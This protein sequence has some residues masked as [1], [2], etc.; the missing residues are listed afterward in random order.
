[1]K[2]LVTGGE[3]FLGSYVVDLLLQN[4]YEVC[5][6]SLSQKKRIVRRKVKYYSLDI[7][8]RYINN[9]FELEKPDYV[10]HNAAHVGIEKSIENPILDAETNI[11]GTL[12]ILEASRT[13]N[14]KKIIYPVTSAIYGIPQ[15]TPIDEIHPINIESPYGVSNYAAE[16]YIK[17]YNKLY[18][19]NYVALRYAN[20]YGTENGVIG[21]FCSL[22]SDG[23]SPCIN[24]N[25]ENE[26]DYV[27]IKDAAR[28]MLMALECDI[29]GVYNVCSSVGVSL[30]RL[31]ELINSLLNTNYKANYLN[32]R[33]WEV[34]SNVMT[35]D[36]LYKEI[37]W[38]P[39]Y[40]IE[41]GLREILQCYLKIEKKKA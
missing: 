21:K 8:D 31:V 24:G 26:R 28:A 19:L 9:I 38:K 5:I 32:P 1:M 2:V 3:G 4:N 13:F 41:Q 40:T 35:Y 37:G 22:M 25:G 33:Q 30:N 11:I 29:Q 36:K 34:V 7:R 20:I 6:V 39:N 14:I 15:Y 10:I 18:Q 16:N 12:N 23:Y 17:V 27:Y